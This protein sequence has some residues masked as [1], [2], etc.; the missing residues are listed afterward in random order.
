MGHRYENSASAASCPTLIWGRME[1]SPYLFYWGRYSCRV[2]FED[3]LNHFGHLYA[4]QGFCSSVEE[5]GAPFT[6]LDTGTTRFAEHLRSDL[7][8]AESNGRRTFH[9][10]RRLKSMFVFRGM[11]K[12]LILSRSTFSVLRRGSSS[13]HVPER[14]LVIRFRCLVGEGTGTAQSDNTFNRFAFDSKP[15]YWLCCV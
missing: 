9:K 6:T 11:P 2:Q 8:L 3:S 15:C 7:R 4:N 5:C 14:R 13:C 10:P 1:I 12:R